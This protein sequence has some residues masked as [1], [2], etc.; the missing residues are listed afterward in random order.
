MFKCEAIRASAKAFQELFWAVMKAKHGQDFASVAPQGRKGDGGN[1]GFL[2]GEKHYF[3]VYAPVEP[4]EKVSRAAKKL[5]TDFAKVKTQW[6][7]KKGDL[8][9]FSFVFNDKYDGAPKDIELKLNELRA[10]YPEVT[11]AHYCCRELESDFMM[12][13]ANDWDGIL[14]GAVPDPSRITNLDYSVLSEVIRFIMSAEFADTETRLDLPPGLDE[15]IRL[16]RLSQ[17]NS[18]IIQHG[19]LLTG[20]IEKYFSKNTTFAL[21]ELREQV[22]GHYETAK[23]VV[24]NEGPAGVAKIDA[25][26]SLFRRSLSPR[27]A[28]AATATAVD[29]VIGYFFEACDVF[30][31]KAAKELPGASP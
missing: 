25:V 13:P 24:E 19:A 8:L 2:P 16:N 4:K 1:D 22:V 20:H 29:A 11:F 18:I 27:N 26:F 12:L 15:K 28:T 5:A 23:R 7:R 31:P 10:K 9:K 30:D 3:Q 21:N 6:G 14:G 17:T